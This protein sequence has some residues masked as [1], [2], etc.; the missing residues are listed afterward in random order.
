MKG[1]IS[2]ILVFASIFLILTFITINLSSTDFNL[3]RAVSAERTYQIQLN[4]KEAM[5]ESAKQ[6]AMNGFEKY[7][8]LRSDEA[9]LMYCVERGVCLLSRPPTCNKP[10][11][12]Q[13]CFKESDAEKAAE[14]AAV[15]NMA[16][17][18]SAF[19][20]DD[21]SIELWCGALGGDAGKGITN[22]L[23]TDSG[24]AHPCPVCTPLSFLCSDYIS[25]DVVPDEVNG[26]YR[27][28]KIRF[29]PISGAGGFGSSVFLTNGEVASV[30]SIPEGYEV[31]YD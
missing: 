14:E 25:A 13:F 9:C 15:S 28:R 23:M 5:I 27:L 2:F 6:G 26:G 17:V 7:S 8:V 18:K 29:S 24:S 21:V 22:S 3:A 11:C 30:S 12:K 31:Y 16:R 19:S 1:Y 4:L 10:S 20:Q